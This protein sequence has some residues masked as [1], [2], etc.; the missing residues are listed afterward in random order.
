MSSD[1]N[2]LWNFGPNA[3]PQTSTQRN[4]AVTFNTTGNHDITL[5]VTDSSPAACSNTLTRTIFSDIIQAD[6]TVDPFFSCDLPQEFTFNLNDPAVDSVVWEFP[7]NM[8]STDL[9]GVFTVPADS[10][11]FGRNGEQILTVSNTVFNARGCSDS[12]DTT[13]VAHAPN[14]LFTIDTTM[15]CAPLTVTFFDSLSTADEN[16]VSYT[17]VWGDGTPNTTT[18][19]DAPVTH[20]YNTDG[21][22]EP[23]L[24]IEN[25]SGC[26]DTSF[27]VPIFVG[28][29]VN[30]D[31]TADETTICPGDTVTFMGTGDA[32]IDAWHFD[33]DGGRLSHCANQANPSWVF[34][35][36]TG[37]MDV[38]LIVLYNGC[39]T[40][41]SRPNFITVNGPL[42]EIDYSIDCEAPFDVLFENLSQDASD[43]QWFFGNGDSSILLNLTFTYPETGDFQVIL[44]AN[45]DM[46]GCPTSFDTVTVSIRDIQA[47]FE[48]PET[49]CIGNE[50]PLDA[51]M[52]TDVNATCW[53][54]YTWFFPSLQ[55]P[56]TTQDSI[57]MFSFGENG[58]REVEL[59]VD[60]INGC[61]NTIRDTTLVIRAQ[62]AFEADPLRLCTP[63]SV[64]FTDLSI[65][66]SDTTIVEW[67]WD[68]GDGNVDSTNQNPTHVYTATPP[69]GT[70]TVNLTVTDI[71]NCEGTA[72]QVIEIYEPQ[73][74]ITV[75]DNRFCVGEVLDFSASQFN[76]EGSFLTYV[77]TLNGQE[78]SQEQVGQIT[79]DNAGDFTLEVIF[80]EEATGC[81]NTS[82]VQ[83]S[84]QD[85]PSAEFMSDGND[86]GTATCAGQVFF[87]NIGSNIEDI[88]SYRWD[89]D[90]DGFLETQTEDIQVSDFYESDTL[91]ITHVATT[92]NG[93][94]DTLLRDYIFVQPDGRLIANENSICVGDEVIFTIAD[95]VDVNNFRIDFADGTVEENTAP[96]LHTFNRAGTFRVL[97]ILE[98]DLG[99]DVCSAEDFVDINVEELLFTI[100]GPTAICEGDNITLSVDDGNPGWEYNW[101][102][103][104]GNPLG[105]TASINVNPTI[106][107][108]FTVTA[109]NPTSGCT[110]TQSISIDVVPDFAEI[111]DT[112][113]RLISDTEEPNIL[114]PPLP[115][116]LAGRND[117]TVGWTNA[118][119]LNLDN[120]LEP[121]TAQAIG[122]RDSLVFTATVIAGPGCD[123]LTF[124]RI[125]RPIRIPNVF[126]PGTTNGNGFFNIIGDNIDTDAIQSIRV[127]NRWGQKVYDN[128]TPA[129]GWNGTFNQENQPPDVYVWIVEVALDDGTTEV[130]TGDVTLVR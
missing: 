72:S 6:F 130:L 77:W 70:Y 10:S 89:L 92:T 30:A 127:F 115:A 24:I 123:T 99:N 51:S 103:G 81:R 52:S 47:S 39:P 98:R 76:D 21:D 97:L 64:S 88:T 71:F 18:T 4:P 105:Q 54:G 3:T 46:S 79:L 16:I 75:N 125:L 13:F 8:T 114:L 124:V 128:E 50:I 48:L 121:F 41:V 11:V 100:N 87:D 31:F 12:F 69:S 9:T 65:P 107:Q 40:T 37:T 85:F 2:Y 119:Q 117:I 93:C 19:N 111:G 74:T 86:D 66:I 22:F 63:N 96:I 59:I 15:G 35:S 36:N 33:A 83:I 129:T 42:A 1:G 113:T 91:T 73:S 126:A 78:I 27:S 61:R 122:E 67:M 82:S 58:E 49:V 20:T 26:T 55:R 62:G 32:T 57:I 120:P 118:N 90:G 68:F 44:E 109:R 106:S 104:A 17:F 60:D 53:K 38:D 95:T 25:A 23:F 112:R 101:V 5:T 116:T 14:A 80:T 34:D 45:N 84:V 56:I 7:M 29:P 94:A 43:G 28:A 110:G 108:T 102:N